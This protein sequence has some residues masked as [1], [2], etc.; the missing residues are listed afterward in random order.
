[1]RLVLACAVLTLARWASAQSVA[2]P[3][4]QPWVALLT[5]PVAAPVGDPG[6]QIAVKVAF[7]PSVKVTATERQSWETQMRAVASYL[8]QTPII[9]PTHGTYPT[10]NGFGAVLAL[11]PFLNTPA[12]API[13]GGVTMMP[14]QRQDVTLAADGTPTLK[15]GVESAGVRVEFNYIYPLSHAI[16]MEDEQGAFGPLILMGQYI[17]YPV[18]DEAL[19]ITRDG[20]LPY[21]AVSQERVL[22][23]FIKRFGDEGRRAQASIDEAR[24]AYDN[25]LAPAPV[26][27]RRSKIDAE[28][29]TLDASNREAQKRYFEMWER[30]DGEKLRKAAQPDLE[31]DA[32]Y[33][34][35]R[36]LRGAE[37]RLAAMNASE[38]ARAAWI[39]ADPNHHQTEVPLLP[40]GQGAAVMAIDPD[41]FDK[42]KPRSV[43]RVALVRQMRHFVEGANEPDHGKA[44]NT[45]VERTN[46]T[47]FQQVNWQEF[48]E[49]FLLVK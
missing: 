27:R 43:M 45:F 31:H 24:K 17:G 29:A 48:A 13:V 32:G 21:V 40:E 8:G 38:R 25:Y 16:W 14:W 1:M 30:S 37:Q 5:Q 26:A 33:S 42:R 23:A 35:L 12:T 2:P 47:F 46:L 6:R 39:D 41:F 20:R 18:I 4:P 34:T 36:G 9:H 49:K 22:K 10:L 28:L 44:A 11:G 15:P 3:A 19:V 7:A